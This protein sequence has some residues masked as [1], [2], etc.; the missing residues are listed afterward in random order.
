MATASI[1]SVKPK[2]EEYTAEMFRSYVGQVFAFLRPEHQ[3]I[4]SAGRVELELLLVSTP[5]GNVVTAASAGSSRAT[6][7]LLFA[8]KPDMPALTAGL[9]RLSHDSFEECDWFLSRV[10]VPGRDSRRAYYEAVFG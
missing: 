2:L 7:S 1:H 5:G 8:L 4:L 3:P 9:H 6:F 10:H